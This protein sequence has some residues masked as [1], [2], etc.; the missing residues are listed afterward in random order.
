[1]WIVFLVILLSYFL[2]ILLFCRGW[3]VIYEGKFDGTQMP[4]LSLVVCAH[5]E[6]EALPRLFQ[7]IENQTYKDFEI[8]LV[9][10]HSEDET[11]RECERWARQ[12]PRAKVIDSA[13][14]GKKRALREALAHCSG[15]YVLQTDADC[16]LPPS[17]VEM[18]ARRLSGE[19]CDVLVCPVRMEG[20]GF[21][22]KMQSFEFMSL[23]GSGAAAIGLRR[24]ILCNGAALAYRKVFR[25]EISAKIKDDIASGDDMFLLVEAK[26]LKRRI[27]F[28]KAKAA[29]VCTEASPSVGAFVRQR[30]RWSSKSI[31]YNDIDII[32]VALLVLAVSLLPLVA[33]IAGRVHWAM[34]SVVIKSLADIIFMRKI[35]TFFCQKFSFGLVFVI[36]LLYPIYVIVCGILGLFSSKK[37]W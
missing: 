35:A 13:G 2:L 15:E 24:P 8:I 12:M 28:L 11:L 31:Y 7:S 5:N 3:D 16:D 19:G 30:M 6:A 23:V 4:S 25:E 29:I 14:R 22:A 32:V 37:R 9:N 34:A 33:L 27:E 10:D 36:E 21:F 26:R 18:V 20:E 17:W 1:M